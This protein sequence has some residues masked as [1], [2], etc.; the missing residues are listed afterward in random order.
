MKS[1]G[2]LNKL[3]FAVLMGLITTSVVV[4]VSVYRA[5]DHVDDLMLRWAHGFA[6]AYP[7]VIVLIL[8]FG[9]RLQKQFFE[10]D[11]NESTPTWKSRIQFVLVM[12]A[13]TVSTA[14][15]LGVTVT[16]ESF[17]EIRRDFLRTFPV[18]YITAIPFILI[19]APRIQSLVDQRIS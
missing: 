9:Q 17:S 7:V 11:V 5:S 19:V 10:F 2:L 18:A 6:L 1:R 3:T 13:I 16:G 15:L 12:A 4:F 8:L 14:C